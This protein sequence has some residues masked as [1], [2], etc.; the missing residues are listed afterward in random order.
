MAT[1]HR[2][3][4]DELLADYQRSH[5]RL[6]EVRHALASITETARSEDGTVQVTVGSQGVLRDLILSE[7]AYQRHRPAQL[8]ALIVRLTAEAARAAARRAE[9][10]LA[11]LLPAGT[12]PAEVLGRADL[13]QPLPERNDPP[14]PGDNHDEDEEDLSGVSWLRDSAQKRSR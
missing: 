14:Y 5:D 9:N 13:E 3:Q 10:L 12:D 11:P 6:A 4:V 7:S 1:D 2:A 8:S